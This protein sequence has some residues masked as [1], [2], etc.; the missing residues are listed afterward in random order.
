MKKQQSTHSVRKLAKVYKKKMNFRQALTSFNSPP[1]HD[2]DGSLPNANGEEEPPTNTR[3]ES[4]E[5]VAELLPAVREGGSVSSSD[6]SGTTFTIEELSES[7]KT[8]SPL[9]PSN[10]DD[11]PTPSFLPDVE[12][13]PTPPNLKPPALIITKAPARSYLEATK[14][15]SAKQPHLLPTKTN[16]NPVKN[17]PVKQPVAQKPLGTSVETQPVKRPDILKPLETTVSDQQPTK[18]TPTLKAQRANIAKYFHDLAE[19]IVQASASGTEDLDSN[20]DTELHN[21]LENMNFNNKLDGGLSKANY[22]AVQK[23]ADKMRGTCMTNKSIKKYVRYQNIYKTYLTLN[24][25]DLKNSES[26][27]TFIMIMSYKYAGSTMWCIYSAINA[28]YANEHRIDI[29]QWADVTRQMKSVTKNHVEKKAA[30]FSKPEM[31]EIFE[32]MRERISKNDFEGHKTRR[33][34]IGIHLAYYGL[35][36][37]DDLL[38]IKCTDLYKERNETG[39]EFYTVKY[40]AKIYDEDDEYLDEA[41]YLGA[42]KNAVEKRKNTTEP[43]TFDLPTSLTKEIDTYLSMIPERVKNDRLIKNANKSASLK[44]KYSQR[45]GQ[46]TIME[47]G[48]TYAKMLKKSN[49]NDYTSHTWRRTGATTLA[50]EGISEVALKR[51]GHWKSAKAA[52]VYVGGSKRSRQEQM[53]LLNCESPR[54]KCNNT[55]NN[56]KPHDNGKTAMAEKAKSSGVAATATSDERFDKTPPIR[57]NSKPADENSEQMRG[58]GTINTTGGSVTVTNIF[59]NSPATADFMSTILNPK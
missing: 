3:K 39:D 41:M 26:F 40:E 46:K 4:L 30:T 20:T 28:W 27:T 44:K 54:K 51:A 16:H 48:R 47:W 50:D 14:A 49:F 23:L 7:L 36:R 2:M 45:T 15:P 42:G 55:S 38:K 8:P 19:S 53:S 31:I 35:C 43:F 24:D 17:Q 52:L 21:L 11:I 58:V 18:K 32:V 5:T 9:N 56:V 13:W 6:Y 33:D 10:L 59:F 22:A 37:T 57:N 34:Y 29:K 12:N 25:L 1:I